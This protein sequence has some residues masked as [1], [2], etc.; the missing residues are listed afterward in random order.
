MA[1]LELINAD[2]IRNFNDQV[3][4]ERVGS[5]VE[6]RSGILIA[7]T[8]VITILLIF[9]LVYMAPED[10]ASDNAGGEVFDLEEKIDDTFPPS[11]YSTFFIVESRDS[12]LLNQKELWELHRN[13]EELRGSELGTY[14]YSSYDVESSRMIL[15]VF[16]IADMVDI[17]L[18]GAFGIGLENATDDQ[19]KFALHFIYSDPETMDMK[20]WLSPDATNTTRTILGQE[21]K[22]WE[23]KALAFL[24]NTDKDLVLDEYASDLDGEDDEVI[25]KENLDRDIQKV[26]RGDETMKKVL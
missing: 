10:T 9:P 4:W 22:V 11:Y 16:T 23:A 1:L 12:D 26:L 7:L 3:I 25:I 8:I 13:Q 19:V 2:R 14:L 24:V 15:G 18:Q 5:L 17:W 20:D 6:K 21:I